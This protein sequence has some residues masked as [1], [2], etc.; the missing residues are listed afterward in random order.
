MDLAFATNDELV[1]ELI[2]RSTFVG[3]VIRSQDEHLRNNQSHSNF[4]ISTNLQP[5][6]LMGLLG[7]VMVNLETKNYREEIVE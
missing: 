1:R 5:D 6:L 4:G 3:A 2:N 7:S